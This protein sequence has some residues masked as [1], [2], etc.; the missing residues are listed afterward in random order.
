[1]GLLEN[2]KEI[3]DLIK[4]AGDID[5]YRKIVE[6]EGEIIDLTRQNR[7]LEE[8]I[9]ELE[10]TVALQKAMEFDEP[11]YRRE[12]DKTPYCPACWEANRLAVHLTYMWKTSSGPRWDCPNCKHT[13]IAKRGRWIVPG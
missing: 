3:A 6:S 7:H 1:M 12:G 4:R 8:R 2:M 9:R 10:R 11:F 5:L 13:Y